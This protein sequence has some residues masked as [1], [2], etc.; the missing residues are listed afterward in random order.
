MLNHRQP[1]GIIGSSKVEPGSFAYQTAYEVSHAFAQD[2][3][4]IICGGR[5]G[6]MEAACKGAR[7]GGG[8]GIAVLPVMDPSKAN[9]YATLVLPTDLGKAQ[10]PLVREPYDISRN[11]IIVSASSCLVAVSGGVGTANE[12]KHGLA[13]GK[14]IYGLCD[15]PDPEALP[16]N[17]KIAGTYIRESDA[18]TVVNKV[19][20]L[21]AKLD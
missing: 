6:V 14:V 4:A 12:I 17:D 7:D 13:F 21:T 10:D 16:A 8:I 1:I 18:E 20:A 19:L 11:R 3:L 2:G 9:D 5:S 15:S